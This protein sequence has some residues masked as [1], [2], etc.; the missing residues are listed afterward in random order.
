M[1]AIH[2]NHENFEQEVLHSQKPV[3]LDFWAAWCNPC[4]RLLPII[5]QVADELTDV[6]VGKIN[7]DDDR[8]LARKF[9]V[10]SIPTLVLVENGKEVARKVG[11]GSKEEVLELVK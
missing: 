2:I 9:R 5:D 3:L 4:Q 6:K 1:S 11:P 7:I 10:M 8:D